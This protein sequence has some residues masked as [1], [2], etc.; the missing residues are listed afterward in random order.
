LREHLARGDFDWLTEHNVPTFAMNR[1]DLLFEPDE[2][3][4]LPG[5]KWRPTYFFA[6]D[7][8]RWSYP[9]LAANCL[10]A[11]RKAF[12]DTRFVFLKEVDLYPVIE[13]K[14]VWMNVKDGCYPDQHI[15]ETGVSVWHP[16]TY[17]L[18][19][20]GMNPI[21]QTAF[22]MG[23]DPICLIGCDLGY[24]PNENGENDPNHFHSAYTTFNDWPWNIRDGMLEE[25]HSNVRMYCDWAGRQIYNCGIGGL[26]QAYERKE[27]RECVFAS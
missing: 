3:E 18:F 25:M 23:F 8:W 21:L 14:V 10:S 5:T 26:L 12:I 16:P 1:I 24:Q 2:D 7:G 4:G 20:G 27:L 15:A 19:G 17:C 13:H 9:Q 6:V 11:A 22:H